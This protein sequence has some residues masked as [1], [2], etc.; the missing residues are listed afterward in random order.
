MFWI[1]FLED[2]HPAIKLVEMCKI[3]QFRHQNLVGRFFFN[4]SQEIDASHTCLLAPLLQRCANFSSNLRK[5]EN[6]YE[7]NQNRFTQY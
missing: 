3:I 6:N 4:N 2:P 5:L 1:Y 7:I